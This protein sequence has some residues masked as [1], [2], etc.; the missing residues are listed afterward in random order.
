MGAELWWMNVSTG[1]LV[2][3]STSKFCSDRCLNW[4]Q[5][6]LP[7]WHDGCPN[8]C[9]ILGNSTQGYAADAEESCNALVNGLAQLAT[10]EQSHCNT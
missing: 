8:N 3:S 9:E 4:V 10:L 7:W 1:E 2:V 5:T 6:E